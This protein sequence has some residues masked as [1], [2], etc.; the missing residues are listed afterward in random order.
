MEGNEKSTEVVPSENAK[1]GEGIYE[2]DNNDENG[3]D[4]RGL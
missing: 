2:Q 3:N 1:T 4:I